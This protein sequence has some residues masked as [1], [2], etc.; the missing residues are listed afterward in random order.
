MLPPQPSHCVHGPCWR[1]SLKQPAQ[2]TDWQPRSQG[3]R[4][5][6][7]S[8][9]VRASDEPFPFAAC[10]AMGRQG[11]WMRSAAHITSCCVGASSTM[12]K[13]FCS[14]GSVASSVHSYGS[15]FSEK[16]LGPHTSYFSTGRA[17]SCVSGMLHLSSYFRR[18]RPCSRHFGMPAAVGT[19]GSCAQATCDRRLSSSFAECTRSSASAP[20]SRAS[21]SSLWS[22]SG[23]SSRTRRF[24]ALAISFSFDSPRARPSSS[25]GSWALRIRSISARASSFAAGAFD[26]GMAGGVG[27]LACAGLAGGGGGCGTLRA[28]LLAMACSAS[29]SNPD[30]AAGAEALPFLGVPGR[31]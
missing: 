21:A 23:C 27:V 3:K 28:L 5:A 25:S 8:S 13:W 9:K 17:G 18:P 11:R 29:C 24:Q 16:Y 1:C 30:G 2:S 12:M 7:G 6:H 19:S 22:L 14:G 10:T 20:A 15:P 4:L 31:A 26:G